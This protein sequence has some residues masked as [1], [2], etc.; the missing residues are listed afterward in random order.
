MILR[1]RR[2]SVRLI[3]STSGAIGSGSLI[4]SH[5]QGIIVYYRKILSMDLA[6]IPIA[7]IIEEIITPTA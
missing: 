4:Q 6:K 1:R 5:V 2:K 3:A 7:R